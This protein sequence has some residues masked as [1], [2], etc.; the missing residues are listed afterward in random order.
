MTLRAQGFIGTEGRK[1]G[2]PAML[3]RLGA[4]QLDTISVLARSHKLV[5]YARLG[6][7]GRAAVE[8]A[9]WGGDAFEYWCHAACIIP[10]D[11][12]PLYGFRRRAFRERR[13]RWHEVPPTVDKVLDRVR[14]DGPITTSDIGGAK[15]GGPWWDWSDSKIAIEWLL[16]IG[17]VVCVKRVG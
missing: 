17:E 3:R 4:V 6:P 14:L 1:G 8:Q 11:H 15:N 7:I 16:D 5:A 9:Y 12:W 10:V 13:F 2:V